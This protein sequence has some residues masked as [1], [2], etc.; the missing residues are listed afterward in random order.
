MKN[1]SFNQRILAHSILH[2]R[3]VTVRYDWQW[4][5]SQWHT[6]RLRCT[7]FILSNSWFLFKR[8]NVSTRQF[9]GVVCLVLLASLWHHQRRALR[10]T[11]FT[12]ENGCNCARKW[13]KRMS[14]IVDVKTKTIFLQF[15]S[16]VVKKKGVYLF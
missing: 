11:C 2:T 1:I 14:L 6:T 4:T 13:L 9:N 8:W 3:C 16:K 12:E 7:Y 15:T 5:P 10:V